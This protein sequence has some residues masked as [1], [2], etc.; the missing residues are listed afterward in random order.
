MDLGKVVW[1]PSEKASTILEA[2]KNIHDSREEIKIIN[3]NSSSED[4]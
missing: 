1:K 2:T 4:D 3:T